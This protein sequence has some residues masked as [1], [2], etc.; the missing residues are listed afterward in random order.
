MKTKEEMMVTEEQL[1]GMADYLAEINVG[2]RTFRT[3][4]RLGGPAPEKEQDDIAGHGYAGAHLAYILGRMEGLSPREAL[5]CAGEFIFHDDPEIRTGDKDKLA[6]HYQEIPPEIVLKAIED[7][8]R[9]LPEEIGREIIEY[10][11]KIE[12]GTS[13]ETDILHDADIV[14]ASLHAKISHERGFRMPGYLLKIYLDPERVRTNSAKRL[15]TALRSRKG[16][17][18]RWLEGSLNV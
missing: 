9:R 17:S 18:V 5:V 4:W 3:G 2:K 16:L 8:T 1:M 15:M 11:M 7:Q 14:E 10:A 6:S 12:S 13:Q